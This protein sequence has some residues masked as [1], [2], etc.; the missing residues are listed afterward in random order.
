MSETSAPNVAPMSSEAVAELLELAVAVASEAGELLSSYAGSARVTA[1]KSTS[2]D[3]VTEA[4]T[5]A[6]RLIRERLLRTRADDAFY[7]EEGGRS[8]GRSG[9][10]W[11]VDPLDGTVNYLY[12]L[13]SYAVSIAAAVG[14]P[15]AERG[16]PAILAGVVV[17]PPTGEVWTAVRGDGARLNGVPV[18]VNPVTELRF[19]L[20]GTGFWYDPELRARQAV[21]LQ[22]LLPAVR[23]IRRIGSA[24]LDLCGVATGRL[25]AFYE[26]GLHPWDHAAGGLIAT[27]AGARLGGPGTAPPDRDLVLAAAPGVYA[28][29]HALIDGAVTL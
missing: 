17:C 1:T 6:E 4:D 27:E 13:P 14:G 20:V 29:L 15:G 3:I 8:A 23:D 9:V 2:T 25:D 24:A 10:T 28:E 26:T 11:I 22:R 21:L 7:G 19:A 5:E 18:T 16:D 12:G